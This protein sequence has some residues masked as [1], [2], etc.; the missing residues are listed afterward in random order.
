MQ[1]FLYLYAHTVEDS[2]L[3]SIFDQFCFSFVFAGVAKNR[4]QSLYLRLLPVASLLILGYDATASSNILSVL[5]TVIF[6][7]FLWILSL[8]LLSRINA[9]ILL[10]LIIITQLQCWNQN[11][12]KKSLFIKFCHAV[13]M[14]S[15]SLALNSNIR[16]RFV[17][18]SVHVI[19]STRLRITDRSFQY[20][21]PGVWNQ[22]PA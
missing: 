2:T 20:A 15:I 19:F 12:G 21:S 14:I 17:W 6:H 7:H 3:M 9:E 13:T 5:G 18:Q 1:L 11:P 16:L 10:I 22:L 8:F 4:P